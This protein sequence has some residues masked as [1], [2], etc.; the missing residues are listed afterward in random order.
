MDTNGKNYL[1]P[2]EVA[3]LFMVS[4]ITIRQWAQ[5]GLLQAEVT[6][7][8]AMLFDP[9]DA[10]AQYQGKILAY[11]ESILQAAQEAEDA[12]FRVR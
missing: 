5:K 10:D 11:R 6:A 1:T 7:G 8:G 12:A 4:P 2:Q 9:H 3:D